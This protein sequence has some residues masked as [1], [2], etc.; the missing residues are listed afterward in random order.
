MKYYIDVDH[1]NLIRVNTT[2]EVA[3]LEFLKPYTTEWILCTHNHIYEREYYLGEGNSC[4]FDIE[5]DDALAMISKWAK[6]E[7]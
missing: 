7:K 4:M 5:E 3:F 2:E 6:K 1:K